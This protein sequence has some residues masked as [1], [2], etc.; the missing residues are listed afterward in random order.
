MKA[1][2]LWQ[3]WATLVAH[4]LKH[5]ETRSWYTSHRGPLAIHAAK[6][7]AEMSELNKVIIKAL[8]D[9]G[10]YKLSELPYGCVVCIA[11]MTDCVTTES[12]AN[13]FYF[14]SIAM[15]ELH[16]GNFNAGRW[17]WRFDGVCHVD[18]VPAKGSQGF[19][20]WQPP[21]SEMAP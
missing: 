15:T 5:F 13:D 18:N 21:E 20:D 6:R 7:K 1:I 16:F 9:I 4:E 17:A 19:W 12:L 14:K 2:S 3:P 8:M 10:Y 11:E